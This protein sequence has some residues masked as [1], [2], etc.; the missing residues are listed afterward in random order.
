MTRQLIRLLRFAWP[1]PCSAVGALFALVVISL[2]GSFK[3][4]GG[5]IEVALR[6]QQIQVPGWAALSA[7]GGITLGHVIIG[8]S[9][10]LLVRLR[11][12]ERVHVRQYEALGPLFFVAYPLASLWA[13]LRGRSP[14]S[15]NVFERQ[16]HRQS[17]GGRENTA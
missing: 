15:E 9:H 12:H 3:R 17:L 13:G 1:S 10:E 2:G 8:Q 7:F 11:E 5:T 14:Y 4:V 6:E 16:A